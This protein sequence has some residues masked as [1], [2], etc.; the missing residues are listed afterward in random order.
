MTAT[1]RSKVVRLNV[2]RAQEAGPYGSGHPIV[3]IHI[4]GSMRATTYLGTDIL[5]RGKK[6]RAILGYLALAHGE[7]VPRARL[8]AML[9]DRVPEGQ[10]RSSFRQALREL[11]SAMGPLADE[12]ILTERE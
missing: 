9:W 1:E 7:R 12:L 8:A 2:G 4:L 11:T 3:R 6:A 10:A 5:P